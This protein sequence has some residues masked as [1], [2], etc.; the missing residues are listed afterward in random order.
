M[1]WIA[2]YHAALGYTPAGPLD[3][4]SLA[5]LH[6]AHV[7]A[8]PF[9]NLDLLLGRRPELSPTALERKVLQER[10]PAYCYELNTLLADYLQRQGL[11][12]TTHLARV[13]LEQ[14]PRQEKPRSHLIITLLLNGERWL[15]DVGFGGGGLCEP[16]PLRVDET[17]DQGQDRY[18]LQ[19]DEEASGWYLQRELDGQWRQMYWFDLTPS[20]PA[21]TEVSNHF[22]ATHPQSRFVRE[23]MLTRLCADGRLVLHKGQLSHRSPAGQRNTAF[24][25]ASELDTL[26]R[27]EFGVALSPAECAQLLPFALGTATACA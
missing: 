7:T 4:A 2:R 8:L 20:Y 21:D 23:L 6:R 16:I 9:G 12:P 24:S 26:L 5:H 11:Q 3:Q 14:T 1:D 19:A 18:R 13:L 27:R 15:L 25:S 10:R 22:V 17:F